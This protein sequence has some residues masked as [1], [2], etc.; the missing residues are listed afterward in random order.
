MGQTKQ[1]L[2]SHPHS[3]PWLT[4]RSA[5]SVARVGIPVLGPR[6]GAAKV[7]G[8]EL[9]QESRLG[10]PVTGSGNGCLSLQQSA[11]Q[12]WPGPTC[13]QLC[14]GGPTSRV[15]SRCTFWNPLLPVLFREPLWLLAAQFCRGTCRCWV[16]GL[17]C[18][19]TPR[20]TLD[21]GGLPGSHFRT[22]LT[23][24]GRL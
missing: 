24:Q 23:R 7:A 16:G 14:Q 11:P 13:R 12:R 21:P 19:G 6:L 18:L 17:C 20:A 2:H 4:C 8:S 22:S 5:P 1:A 3:P 9:S 10:L 15:G